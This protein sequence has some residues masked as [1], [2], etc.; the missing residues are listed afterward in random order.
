MLRAWHGSTMPGINGLCCD[1]N[2]PTAAQKKKHHAAEPSPW[3]QHS[4]ALVLAQPSYPPAHL[5]I[6]IYTTPSTQHHLHITIYTTP[7]TQH[8]LHY[9]V[10]TTSSTHTIYTTS[11]KTTS[12][13]QPH[14]HTWWPQSR[15]SRVQS[16]APLGGRAG[17]L[18]LTAARKGTGSVTL[19]SER[20]P[21]QVVPGYCLE[22]LLPTSSTHHHLHNTIYRCSTWSTAILP[23]LPHSCW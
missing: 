23:L 18:P 5:H 16:P 3:G 22:K 19:Q 7:S 13:T 9:V 17:S 6:T 11:S 8:H 14:Q 4:Y 10:N 15:W 21:A 20:N 12:S 2:E 1:R